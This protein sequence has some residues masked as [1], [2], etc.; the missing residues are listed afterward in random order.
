LFFFNFDSG[1][2]VGGAARQPLIPVAYRLQVG[3][4]SVRQ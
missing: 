1:A 3:H 2:I 4:I